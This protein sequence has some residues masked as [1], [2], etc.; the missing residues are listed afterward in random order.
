M[1]RKN[2]Y[3]TLFF[4]K[5]TS[6]QSHIAGFDWERTRRPTT[7]S[8]FPRSIAR[9]RLKSMDM[10]ALVESRCSSPLDGV[11]VNAEYVDQQSV[12]VNPGSCSQHTSQETSVHAGS[13]F[14]QL[15]AKGALESSRADA[16]S[17]AKSKPSETG[18]EG[19]LKPG[20]RVRL[21]GLQQRSSLNGRTGTVRHCLQRA[22]DFT[23][24]E[25]YAM[26]ELD[27][28]H[29]GMFIPN[30]YRRAVKACNL[31]VIPHHSTDSSSSVCLETKVLLAGFRVRLGG[32]CAHA[33]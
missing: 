22:E 2:S 1:C 8:I 10:M 19:H 3:Q 4:L 23:T 18:D 15:V 30:G 33:S 7:F 29:P 9:F 26:V 16:S 27:P 13:I 6:P 25:L 12:Y 11:L 31:I 5:K 14:S 32:L 24:T 21:H 20:C 17:P 28:S